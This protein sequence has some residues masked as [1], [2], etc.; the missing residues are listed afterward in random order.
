MKWETEQT[1]KKKRQII[2]DKNN[3]NKKKD[4][5]KKNYKYKFKPEKYIGAFS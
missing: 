4:K 3:L 1:N 2:I 5:N